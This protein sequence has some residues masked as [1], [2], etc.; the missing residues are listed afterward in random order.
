MEFELE[1]QMSELVSNE[2]PD[3]REIQ[4][5]Y[6]QR[7]KRSKLIRWTVA[8][9]ASFL[10]LVVVV[11]FAL[12]DVGKAP[13]IAFAV[14]VVIFIFVMRSISTVRCPGCEE[15]IEK[16]W[17]SHCPEC[18]ASGLAAVRDNEANCAA[19]QRTL[20]V[21]YSGKGGATLH[22]GSNY[23]TSCGVLLVDQVSRKLVA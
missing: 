11:I 15:E 6:S 12:N 14:A 23:C 8:I 22:Y 4:R 5:K 9:G 16:R 19:C 18:G 1:E 20:T 10:L 17:G 2:R 7:I 3:G 13:L 21:T